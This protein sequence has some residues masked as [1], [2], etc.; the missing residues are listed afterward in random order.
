M[1]ES[2]AAARERRRRAFPIRIGV[3]LTLVT[4]LS[5]LAIADAT[6]GIQLQW[7][8][9]TSLMI[10]GAAMLVALATRRWSW[11]VVPLL[12][13]ATIGA[14]AFAG[15]DASLHDGIGQREWKPATVTD[16]RYRL[17]FGQGVLDLRDLR[18]T[19]PATINV[20]LGAGQVRIIAPKAMNASV[21]VDVHA[22]E[23][24]IDRE[25]RVHGFEFT[26]VVDPLPGAS[27]ARVTLDVHLTDGNVSV[28]RR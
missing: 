8:F 6:V 1:D 25:Q 5:C 23:L 19:T 4:A 18:L 21:H 27:G 15:S 24:E 11:S 10:L 13:P 12:V 2:R 20:T 9:W 17:A 28:E 7:Y 22:G 14:I 26:R 3:L 16:A